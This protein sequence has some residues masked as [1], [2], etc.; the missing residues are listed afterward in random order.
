MN[1]KELLKAMR[2]GS[3]KVQIPKMKIVQ[4]KTK[5]NRKKLK[6]DIDTD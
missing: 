6:K 4:D 1:T 3:R 5:Y 2:R